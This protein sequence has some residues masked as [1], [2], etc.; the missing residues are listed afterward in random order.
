MHYNLKIYFM[1]IIIQQFLYCTCLYL[2][3]NIT[4]NSNLSPPWIQEPGRRPHPDGQ[5]PMSS[6]R[7]VLPLLANRAWTTRQRPLTPTSSQTTNGGPS[8]HS[9]T[10]P[11]FARARWSLW[12]ALMRPVVALGALSSCVEACGWPWC[13]WPP[14]SVSRWGPFR[15]SCSHPLTWFRA[16]DTAGAA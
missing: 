8:T 11:N 2:F 3:L 9:P 6:S 5:T 4:S 15:L 14:T 1:M 12:V 10:S 16:A 7:P 13:S